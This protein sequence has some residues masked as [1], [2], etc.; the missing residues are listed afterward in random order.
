ML[1]MLNCWCYNTMLY[2]YELLFQTISNPRV[3]EEPV[4][5]SINEL[6]IMCIVINENK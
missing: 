5:I 1:F 4:L 6:E 3:S 2:Y